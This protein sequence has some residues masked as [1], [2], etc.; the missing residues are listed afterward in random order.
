[1][2][3]N[4]IKTALLLL[5]LSSFL[6]C[7]GQVKVEQKQPITLT[8]A[9]GTVVSELDSS[10]WKIFQ[11][12]KGNYW[13]GSNGKG[14]YKYDEKTLKQFM[15]KDGL[16][17]NQIRGIQEDSKGNLYFETP[18]GI[19]K[20]N[21]QE[22]ST[23]KAIKSQS[24][25]WKLNPNDLWFGY[26]AKDL[27][28]FDGEYLY[29]LKLP[30]K[31]LQTAF[32]KEEASFEENNNSPYAVYGVNKDKEGNIWFGT[33]TAGAYRYDGKTL[34]WFGEKE[35]S[36]LPDGRVPGVRS[37]LQDKDGYFWLSNFFSKYKINPNL[38]KGYEKI[39]A[40]DLQKEV[41]KDKLLYFNAGI[42]DKDGNLWMT[43][44][45]ESI[46]KYDGKTLSNL[47]IKKDREKVLLI[48]ILQD[49][50]GT[51]WLGSDNDGVYKQNGAN[52]EKFKLNQ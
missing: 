23:L 46:W 47:E 36:T 37:L 49:N 13:F 2:T 19:S 7:N 1:M 51:I 5:V 29:E 42:N 8:P 20:Y 17:H 45:N 18:Q 52:F 14:I 43:T 33:E 3:Y 24:N 26:N 30:R 35:L 27:Y 16:V 15:T 6:S 25:E 48:C 50:K 32:G 11:D 9:I 28:R 4:T 44:Y 10:I 38:P 40:V 41:V 31:D 21:G 12:S 22:F 34:L 39:K